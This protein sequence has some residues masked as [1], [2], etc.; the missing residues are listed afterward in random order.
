MTSHYIAALGGYRLLY[1]LNWIIRALT[2]EKYSAWL[3]WS[4]GFVQNVIFADFFYHYLKSMW[5]KK[6]M[7]LPTASASAPASSVQISEEPPA[8]LRGISK[9]VKKFTTRNTRNQKAF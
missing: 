4:A 2:E 6:K 3:L 7:T 9:M 8:W 1:L 5:Y